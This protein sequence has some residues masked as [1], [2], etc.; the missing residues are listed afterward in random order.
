MEWF[1]QYKRKNP[2]DIKETKKKRKLRCNKR[3]YARYDFR[4]KKNVKWTQ[5]EK[6]LILEHKEADRILAQKI[7]RSINSIQSFRS[8]LKRGFYIKKGVKILVTI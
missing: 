1:N 6:I 2:A 8:I 7:N 4:I 5:K 3:Y